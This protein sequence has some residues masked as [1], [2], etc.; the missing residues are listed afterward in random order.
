V[1]DPSEVADRLISY[2][3]RL[4][5][6]VL[7]LVVQ[8]LGGPVANGR[9]DIW[10]SRQYLAQ[11]EVARTPRLVRLSDPTKG[12]SSNAEWKAEFAHAEH[13]RALGAALADALS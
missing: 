7:E 9:H 2:D 13:L 5:A 1:S 6:D 3:R 4:A 8:Q 11:L 10:H 12:D